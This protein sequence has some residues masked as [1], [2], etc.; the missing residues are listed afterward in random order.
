MNDEDM[1]RFLANCQWFNQ[2]FDGLR[3]FF[4]LI[5]KAL[6]ADFLPDDFSETA[7][8]YYFTRINYAPT[9]PQFYCL[10]LPGNSQ[11]LQVIAVLDVGLF[12][13]LSRFRRE[14]SIVTV[15]HSE[16][17][18]YMKIYDHGLKVVSGSGVDYDPDSGESMVS[19]TI[20]ASRPVRFAARQITLDRL[21]SAEN[22]RQTIEQD[23]VGLIER[24]IPGHGQPH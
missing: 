14:P 23:I 24:G 20:L 13:A 12:T 2:F 16:P 9:M 15:I 7:G 4:G 22:V 3:Q 10:G 11:A 8:N 5:I 6:P 19:G 18:K 17:S 1:S 21:S